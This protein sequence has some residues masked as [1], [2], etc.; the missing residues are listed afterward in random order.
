MF[1]GPLLLLLP[2]HLSTFSEE[3]SL[4]FSILFIWAY[5]LCSIFVESYISKWVVTFFPC[6]SHVTPCLSIHFLSLTVPSF[7]FLYLC[8]NCR[9]CC[10]LFVMLC[11]V[12]CCYVVMLCCYVMLLLCYVSSVFNDLIALKCCCTF[13]H[14]SFCTSLTV[15]QNSFVLTSRAQ[16]LK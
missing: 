1:L 4:N 15:L 11:Y 14:L 12:C 13:C 9:C 16:I 10:L 3:N 5:F 2:L 7:P 6:H 8:C